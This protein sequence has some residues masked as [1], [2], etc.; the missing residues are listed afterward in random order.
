M[1]LNT[2]KVLFSTVE[3]VLR[4]FSNQSVLGQDTDCHLGLM[5]NGKCWGLLKVEKSTFLLHLKTLYI[6]R[7]QKIESEKKVMWKMT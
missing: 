2:V 6:C 3:S 5:L 7:V 1:P 4:V